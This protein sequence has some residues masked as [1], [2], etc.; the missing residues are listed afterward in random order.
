MKKV[1]FLSCMMGVL[2]FAGC[3]AQVLTPEEKAKKVK[4]EVQIIDQLEKHDFTF[5]PDEMEP[6]FGSSHI[7]NC[8]S[9]IF[10][11]NNKNLEVRLPYFGHFFL[12]PMNFDDVPLDFIS[13]NFLY[14]LNTKDRVNFH[15][16]IVPQDAGSIMNDGIVFNLFVDTKT[17]KTTLKAKTDNRDEISF[18]GYIR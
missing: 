12:R 10:R 3:K 15:V 13:S 1:I 2:L 17:G 4:A 8:S 11:V 16:Q 5:Y 18:D 9:C 6:E 14:V 7:L